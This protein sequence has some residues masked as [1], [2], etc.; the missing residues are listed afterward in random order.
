MKC[1]VPIR[2]TANH[3]SMCSRFNGFLYTAYNKTSVNIG[4]YRIKICLYFVDLLVT[5]QIPFLPQTSIISS[6]SITY[7]EILASENLCFLPFGCLLFVLPSFQSLCGFSFL[8][9]FVVFCL[10]S[11]TVCLWLLLWSL[12]FVFPSFVVVR[13]FFCLLVSAIFV[14]VRWSFL[15]GGRF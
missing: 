13:G 4:H 14:C 15:M 7:I 6:V 3:T 5:R 12:L 8:S 11:L 2:R 9:E 1:F 10:L